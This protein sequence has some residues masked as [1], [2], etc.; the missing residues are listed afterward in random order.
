M[1]ILQS[2]C[3][4]HWGCQYH[5]VLYWQPQMELKKST[6][7]VALPRCFVQFLVYFDRNQL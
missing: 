6:R 2:L 1:E 5:I 3:H 7:R 4:T